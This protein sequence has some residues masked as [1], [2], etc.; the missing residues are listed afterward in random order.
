MRYLWLLTLVSV[1]TISS[2]SGQVRIYRE[3]LTLPTYRVLQPEIMP[4]WD[5]RRYPYPMLD[6]ITNEKYNKT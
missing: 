1:C 3:P 2:L 6:R 5:A 4:D